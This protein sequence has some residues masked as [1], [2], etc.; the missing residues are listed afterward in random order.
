MTLRGRV[1]LLLST[2]FAFRCRQLG[3][4]AIFAV[5]LIIVSSFQVIPMYVTIAVTLATGVWFTCFAKHYRK[6]TEKITED[7]WENFLDGR[8]EFGEYEELGG[9]YEHEN[10]EDDD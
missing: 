10:S 3:L 8:E 5:L 7:G 4:Q 2:D 6:T 1:G 9:K